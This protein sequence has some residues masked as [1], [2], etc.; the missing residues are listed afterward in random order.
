VN[1]VLPL[2]AFEHR[3]AQSVATSHYTDHIF[4]HLSEQAGA[5][6][7]DSVWKW[8]SETCMKL[9]SAECTVRNSWWWAQK[10]PETC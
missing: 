7:P 8:S 9:T 6:H 1:K 5:F 10:M 2:T 4:R 3:N